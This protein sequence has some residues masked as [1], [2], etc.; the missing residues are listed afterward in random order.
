MAN[1]FEPTSLYEDTNLCE[2]VV[3]DP[4]VEI[5]MLF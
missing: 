3:S 1:D 5:L 4:R 2:N